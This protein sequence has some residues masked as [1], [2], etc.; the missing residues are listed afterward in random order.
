MANSAQD[1]SLRGR[2]VLIVED[3]M[4]VAMELDDLLRGH[5]CTVLGPAATIK[6]AIALIATVRPDAALLDLNLSGHTAVP[7]AAALNGQE[8]PFV[9]VS[10]YSETHLQAPEL[11]RAPRLA[12]PVDHARFL[13]ELG[14]L[15][16][17]KPLP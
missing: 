12:K 5:G 15:L 3:E 14:M 13:G 6:T 11:S 2:C 9:I 10:G 7:V 8:V 1:T 17:E 16:A 4:L